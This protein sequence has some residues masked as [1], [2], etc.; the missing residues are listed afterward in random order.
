MLVFATATPVSMQGFLSALA[1]WAEGLGARIVR[2]SEPRLVKKGNY[3]LD[4]IGPVFVPS[5]N[6]SAWHS[7]DPAY[8]DSL[9][10]DTTV[11]LVVADHGFAGSALNHQIA[12]VG[13][14]DT[15]DPALPLAAYLGWQVT[16]VPMN[17]NQYNANGL[18]LADFLIK[19]FG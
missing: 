1:A 5:D 11:D 9:L 19:Q 6:C 8:L 17:D 16:A 10:V 2:I 7:H 4:M 14:Y 13:F 3:Y 15:N 18:A 12:C